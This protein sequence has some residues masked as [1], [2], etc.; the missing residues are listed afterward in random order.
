VGL[1][2][3]SGTPSIATILTQVDP[4]N[5][6][7]EKGLST[8]FGDLHDPKDEA[9]EGGKDRVINMYQREMMGYDG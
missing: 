4:D 7:Q 5:K 2:W 9:D 8:I 3:F 1:A 6:F